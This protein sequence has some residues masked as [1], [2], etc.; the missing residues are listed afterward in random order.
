MK[1]IKKYK[2]RKLYLEKYGEIRMEDIVNMVRN[3]EDFIVID[4]KT[5]E[6]ITVETLKSAIFT[7]N[8]NRFDLENLIRG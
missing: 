2:N 3:K 7:G 4:Q 1:K 5:N 8:Y 6:D